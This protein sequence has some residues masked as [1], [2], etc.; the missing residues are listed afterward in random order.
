MCTGALQAIL[1]N[2]E[3]LQM[4]MD[5]STDYCSRCANGIQD[6]MGEFSYY[7][8]LKLSN[9]LFSNTEQLVHHSP[10]P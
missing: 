6:N 5:A 8:G 10:M 3:S 7:F 1:K 2:Y 4:T 9:F